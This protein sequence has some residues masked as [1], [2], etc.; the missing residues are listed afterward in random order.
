MILLPVG[1]FSLRILE[2]RI[3]WYLL[4]QRKFTGGRLMG[5]GGARQRLCY[6]ARDLNSEY[7]IIKLFGSNK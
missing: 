5:G 2:N 3:F 1:I 4:M 7:G 6:K